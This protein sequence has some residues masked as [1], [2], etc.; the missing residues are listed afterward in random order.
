MPNTNNTFSRFGF[1]PSQRGFTL[2]ELLV[3]IAIISILAV[4]GLVAFGNIQ[5]NARDTRRKAD[6]DAITKALEANKVANSNSYPAIAASY[7]TSGTIPTDTG[8]NQYCV[9]SSATAGSVAPADPA[10]WSGGGCPSTWSP[11]A[12]NVPPVSTVSFKVC[13]LLESGTVYCRANAQ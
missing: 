12:V 4:I 7:F 8:T 10:P 11:V 5:K 2:I 3:T 6:I 13:A 1:S 9:S